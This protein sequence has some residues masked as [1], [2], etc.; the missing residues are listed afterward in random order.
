MKTFMLSLALF[1]VLPVGYPSLVNVPTDY[2]GYTY[3]NVRS[4]HRQHGKSSFDHPV[5]FE[6]FLNY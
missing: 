5:R 6:F 3:T 1:T 2:W 4:V